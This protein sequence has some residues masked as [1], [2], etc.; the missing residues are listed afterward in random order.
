MQKLHVVIDTAG[1]QELLGR[2]LAS[3]AEG[4]VPAALAQTI[5]IEN[6]PPGGARQIVSQAPPILKTRYLYEPCGNKSGALNRVLDAIDDGL[7]FFADDDVRFHPGVLRDYALA[8]QQRSERAFFGGPV[9]VD[10]EQEP[11]EWLKQYLPKSARGWSLTAETNLVNE[12]DFL[13][14][15]WA[16]FAKDLK[17]AG[18]FDPFRGPGAVT[19]SVGQESDMQRRLLQSDCQGIYLPGACVWHYVPADR[20]SPEWALERAYRQGIRKGIDEAKASP[21]LTPSRNLRAAVWTAGALLKWWSRLRPLSPGQFAKLRRVK[22]YQGYA[23]G[24]KTQMSGAIGAQSSV[25][26]PANQPRERL[27]DVA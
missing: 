3:L 21:S 19:G 9:A 5:V 24:W 1:R 23:H 18:G 10:Y 13:G 16:A 11:P 20:C 6:G 25:P 26:V 7:I 27:R 2:T 8:A 22:W 14:C 15:N 17:R 4:E 12:P